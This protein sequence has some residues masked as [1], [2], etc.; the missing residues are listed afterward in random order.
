MIL[1]PPLS[2]LPSDGIW[3]GKTT[4]SQSTEPLPQATLV[5]KKLQGGESNSFS[6]PCPNEGKESVV[7]SFKKHP[8]YNHRGNSKEWGLKVRDLHEA[9]HCVNCLSKGDRFKSR[10]IN[11]S[12][13]ILIPTYCHPDSCFLLDH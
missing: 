10:Y 5:K 3:A 7:R 12:L 1:G 6:L 11:V 9:Q 2:I 4:N 8:G 13:P